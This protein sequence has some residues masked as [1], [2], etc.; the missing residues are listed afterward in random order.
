M[1]LQSFL[2]ASPFTSR[3]TLD[4]LPSTQ[5]AIFKC[6][7]VCLPPAP[8]V[9]KNVT[10]DVIRARRAVPAHSTTLSLAAQFDTVLARELDEDAELEHPLDGMLVITV[11]YKSS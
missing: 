2:C 6:L 11:E 3:S 8:Q 1:D 4:I 10:T 5:I 7:T 9:T